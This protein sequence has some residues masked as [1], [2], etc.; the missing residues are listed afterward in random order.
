MPSSYQP[1][2]LNETSPGVP[3]PAP[4]VEVTRGPIVESRHRG[5]VAAVDGAGQLVA[6]LGEP[7][8]VTYLRSSAKPFQALPLVTT[9]AADRFGFTEK[10]IALACASHSGEPIHTETVLSMLN[11]IGLGPEAL[12]CGVH[13][14]FSA[15]ETRRLREQ[16]EEPNVLQNNCSGK[17][18][19]MLALALHLGAPT[20]SYNQLDNPIQAVI[21]DTVAKFS[22]TP[23]QDLAIGIDGCA[24]PCF[25][26][27][28]SAM[29]RMYAHLVSPP[30]GFADAARA[31]C[32]R[33]VA[34][35]IEYPEMIGGTTDRLD[36]EMMRAAKGR[37]ISKIGAE[38]VYTV[39]VLPCEEGR[40]NATD[41]P[42]L[43]TRCIHQRGIVILAAP[44]LPLCIVLRLRGVRHR[45]RPVS[46]CRA[47]GG[48]I[49]QVP[50][51]V[52]RGR[53]EPYR[54]RRQLPHLQHRVALAPQHGRFGKLAASRGRTRA[55]CGLGA[56]ARHH[57]QHQ[58]SMAPQPHDEITGHGCTSS[59]NS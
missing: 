21:R 33:I 39:G 43:A 3:T 27:S 8:T 32:R 34:A 59:P 11:K 40:L 37:V 10:E 28:V 42:H 44:Q 35:M 26:V 5:H 58:P 19:G 23:V 54:G 25:G 6:Y 47:D 49:R 48:A 13:E 41:R 2:A 51:R 17:H 9:G 56:A 16:G 53:T 52:R 14:P 36:T 7:D 46:A 38:G 15:E 55:G 12:K 50:G 22:G 4:L 30:I 29:A 1:S 57:G 31:A 20:E 24:V 45:P 18:A